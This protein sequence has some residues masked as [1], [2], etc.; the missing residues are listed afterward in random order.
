M[1]YHCL[2]FKPTQQMWVYPVK[3]NLENINSHFDNLMFCCLVIA[4][5]GRTDGPKD[6]SD[7]ERIGMGPP[8]R[9]K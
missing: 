1:G 8:P 9:K 3:K 7:A 2:I 6:K 4:G 5:D